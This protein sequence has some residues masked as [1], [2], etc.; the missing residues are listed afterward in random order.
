MA[1][2]SET[3]APQRQSVILIPWDP[4]SAEHVDRMVA[5][6]IACGWKQA[7]VEAWRQL[8]REGK[9]GLHWIVNT[10]ITH[11]CA[12]CLFCSARAKFGFVAQLIRFRYCLQMKRKRHKGSSSMSQPSQMRQNP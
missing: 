11:P 9:I 7:Y 6:R 10:C 8:Q 2:P 3:P 1:A 4:D 12:R 5:Q